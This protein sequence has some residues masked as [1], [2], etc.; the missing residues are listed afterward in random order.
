METITVSP[1]SHREVF[2]ADYGSYLLWGPAPKPR[3]LAALDIR[4]TSESR[5]QKV[6]IIVYFY[7]CSLAHGL[8]IDRG[9]HH[10]PG[11][12]TDFRR[13]YGHLVGADAAKSSL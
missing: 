12:E 1:K 4:F 13:N 3:V 2:V 5:G 10:H 11:T 8:E 7:G 6:I 9:N